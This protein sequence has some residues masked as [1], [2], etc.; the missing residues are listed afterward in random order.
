MYSN[1]SVCG[2]S[3]ELNEKLYVKAIHFHWFGLVLKVD[4]IAIFTES[5][6]LDGQISRSVPPLLEDGSSIQQYANNIIIFMYHNLERPGT[7]NY[8]FLTI[9]STIRT[10]GY[11]IRFGPRSA[12][13]A[14]QKHDIGAP[15]QILFVVHSSK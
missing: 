14:H 9:A 8:V 5:A 11:M 15:H 1:V 3:T 13:S 10:S 12:S 4:M 2:V 7:S 6:E